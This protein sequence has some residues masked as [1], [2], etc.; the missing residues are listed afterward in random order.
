MR[1]AVPTLLGLLLLLPASALAQDAPELHATYE[2]YAAGLHVAEVE[3]ALQVGA[4]HYAI[5]IAYHTTGVASLFR[6]GHQL[7][8]VVGTW[9]G[10]QPEPQQF[11]AVGQWRDGP[12]A[13]VLNYVDGQPVIARLEPTDADKREPVP[14]TVQLNSIDSLSAL[15]LLVRRAQETGRCDATAHTFDGRRASNISAHTVDEETLG[16]SS[17]SMFSGPALRCDFIGQMVA[18]FL[19]ADDTPADRK[20][21]HGSAW[22]ATVVPG[23]PPVPVR[24]DFETRWFGEAHM[25]LTHLAPVPSTEV[26]AH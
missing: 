14:R 9:N 16:Q 1:H 5:T 26:A 6:P 10:A 18:G 15:A 3:V 4:R 7:N 12:N 21:L 24:M 25:Y 11:R 19:F 2:M 22:L 23:A 8:S 13:T 20:P 17:L